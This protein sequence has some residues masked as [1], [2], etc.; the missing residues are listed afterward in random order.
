MRQL[1]VNRT[2]R[3]GE[4]TMPATK[5]DPT[6]RF[7]TIWDSPIGDLRIVAQ[8]DGCL[9]LYFLEHS[10]RP[11]YWN[12]RQRIENAQSAAGDARILTNI[13]EQLDEYFQCRRTRFRIPCRLEGTPFQ[14]EVWRYLTKIAPGETQTYREVAIGIGRPLAIRA[15]GAAIARNP[16]SLLVPCHRVVGTN[17]KLTGFAGGLDRKK[18]LLELEADVIKPN[19]S[20]SL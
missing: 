15:V 9:G 20:G 16:I 1:A 5:T 12:S 3:L 13:V 8:S 17:G 4:I 2:S 11:R 18:F 7:Q 14:N 10:P 19:R 6:T